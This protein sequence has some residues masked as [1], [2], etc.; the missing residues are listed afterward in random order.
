[1]GHVYPTYPPPPEDFDLTPLVESMWAHYRAY[2]QKREPLQSMAYA[3]LAL[4]EATCVPPKNGRRKR[5]ASLHNVE[6]DV[7]NT[8]GDLSS[9]RRDGDATRKDSPALPAMSDSE[10]AWLRAAI[11]KL[12][13]HLGQRHPNRALTMADLPGL[14]PS[15]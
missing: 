9:E 3:C 5:A 13:V 6:V 7:L 11:P 1:V 15:P 12:I 14:N 10:R 8:I 2:R 4:I